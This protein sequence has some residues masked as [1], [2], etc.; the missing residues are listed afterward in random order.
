MII[1]KGHRFRLSLSE[2]QKTLCARTAGICRWLWNLALEQRTLAWQNGRHSVG[3]A[4]QCAELPGLKDAAPWLREAPSHCLQQVLRD[5]DQAFQ[6]FFAGRTAYPVYRKKFQND[7]FRFPDP[8]QFEVNEAGRWIKL[9]KFRRVAMFNGRGRHALKLAGQAK[10]ITVR[11]E[12]KRWYAAVLCA[13]EGPEPKPNH[14]PAVG[15]DLG[16]VQTI[17][18]SAGEVLAIQGRTRAEERRLARLQRSLGRKRKGSR[19]R[20]KARARLAELQIRIARRRRDAIHKATTKLAKNHGLIV[21][22]DLR[23]KA[24]T[25]SARGTLEAPGTNVSAKAGLNRAMLNVAFG[26]IRRQL[27]YKCG[28]YGSTL[29]AANPVHT[30]R[31]CSQCGHTDA[32]NRRSQATFH[33]L[34]C[35][36]GANADVNAARNIL[37]RGTAEG[38]PAAVCGAM[39][40]GGRRSRNPAARAI[41]IPSF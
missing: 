4:A 33:C 19:N 2:E 32:G 38:T 28:W 23:V 35:G 21:I 12:G 10:S 11:R 20:A 22:E 5:L 34:S 18:L 36:H 25:A 30:S 16:V 6:N 13:W 39:P 29:L 17:T 9:P 3:F 37:E 24:M 14:G 1:H 31:R 41:R 26:E 15:L 8:K 7:S 27:E 40:S